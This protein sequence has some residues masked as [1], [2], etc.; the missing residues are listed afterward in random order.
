MSFKK[1]KKISKSCSYLVKTLHLPIKDYTFK[2]LGQKS[3]Q[4]CRKFSVIKL[5]RQ[6]F[7]TENL[8]GRLNAIKFG[9]KDLMPINLET[10]GLNLSSHK[11]RFWLLLPLYPVEVCESV[12]T[13]PD[14]MCN[15]CRRLA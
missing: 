14:L 6:K 4:K 13:Y 12:A 3:L 1:P 8:D 7:D 2:T 10:V 11:I 5:L 15:L 9:G